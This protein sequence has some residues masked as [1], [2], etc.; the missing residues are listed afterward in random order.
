MEYQIGLG[1]VGLVKNGPSIIYEVNHLTAFISFISCSNKKLLPKV[2]PASVD[3]KSQRAMDKISAAYWKNERNKACHLHQRKFESA[4]KDHKAISDVISVG[5]STYTAK[6]S[7]FRWSGILEDYNSSF[8]IRCG[9]WKLN[10][11]KAL[12][13]WHLAKVTWGGRVT[14]SWLCWWERG[15]PTSYSSFPVCGELTSSFN[16]PIISPREISPNRYPSFFL[17]SNYDST[18]LLHHYCWWCRQLTINDQWTAAQSTS[19]NNATYNIQHTT[20]KIRARQER[21]DNDMKSK[22]HTGTVLVSLK[23]TYCTV[24]YCTVRVE[25][26]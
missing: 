25:Y 19:V 9:L 20:Y 23:Y 10:L 14:L 3:W 21:D 18:V 26:S 12:A 8:L 2:K 22:A 6:Q 4:G 11:M 7:T 16:F 17:A 1:G 5:S 15:A 24:E 13:G